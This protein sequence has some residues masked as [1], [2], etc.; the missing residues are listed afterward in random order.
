MRKA[1]TE[2]LTSPPSLYSNAA[3]QAKREERRKRKRRG[4]TQSVG[5]T[6]QGQDLGIF[7]FNFL[8]TCI[9]TQKIQFFFG[10]RVI[11]KVKLM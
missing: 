11:C 4:A 7:T 1:A 6:S 3:R 5:P 2:S 8:T 10:I 9:S